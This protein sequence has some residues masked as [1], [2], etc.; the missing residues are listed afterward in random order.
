MIVMPKSQKK[1]ITPIHHTLI[2]DGDI[3]YLNLSDSNRTKLKVK[4]YTTAEILFLD[5]VNL[6][7]D[8]QIVVEKLGEPFFIYQGKMANDEH[9][10]YSYG[11]KSGNN[12]LKIQLHF[13]EKSFLIGIILYRSYCFDYYELNN[14][15]KGKFNLSDF[16]LLRDIIVD[17]FGNT[18]EFHIEPNYIVIVFSKRNPTKFQNL[19]FNDVKPIPTG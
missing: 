11:L 17:P 7:D 8:E 2:Y 10:V 4:Q 16:S 15:Y 5:H 19:I 14:N 1:W 13:I 3:R 12:K 9:K 18:I 6:G